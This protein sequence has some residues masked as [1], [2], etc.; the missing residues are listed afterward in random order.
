[1]ESGVIPIS[2]KQGTLI[3][4]KRIGLNTDKNDLCLQTITR[5]VSTVIQSISDV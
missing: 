5:S 2:H 3:L 1:M 4:R